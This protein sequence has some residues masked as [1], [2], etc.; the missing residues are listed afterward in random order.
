SSCAFIVVSSQSTTSLLPFVSNTTSSTSIYTLSL[1]DALPI[2]LNRLLNGTD[3]IEGTKKLKNVTIHFEA[4]NGVK[5]DLILA[6]TF[7]NISNSRAV[8]IYKENNIQVFARESDS[9]Y[10]KRILEAVGL[11]SLVRVT[12]VHVHNA[13][14]VDEFLRVTKLINEM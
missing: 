8:E 6:M 10:S 13:A 7:S 4:A 11:E 12:P 9:H 14:D 5:Q 1:H 3:S 2:F